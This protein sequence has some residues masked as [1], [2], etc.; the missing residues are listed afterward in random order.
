MRR[1]QQRY[2]SDEG[3]TKLDPQPYSGIIM[4]TFGKQNV[5]G[6][7]ITASHDPSTVIEYWNYPMY[8]T[9]LHIRFSPV[10][11]FLLM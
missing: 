6:L 7:T 1:N 5:G 2:S 10:C 3:I 4:V 9:P 8:Q 11:N